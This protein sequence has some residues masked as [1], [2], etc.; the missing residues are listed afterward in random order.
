MRAE[1]SV[2]MPSYNVAPYIEECLLSVLRQSLVNIEIICVD[3]GSTDGTREIIEKYSQK[4]NRIIVID[5]PKKSYGLQM[6]L[7]I[8]R[9]TGEYIGI[10]ETDDY[11]A[12]D[13][14][15]ILYT[16]AV[17]N[18]L[19]CVRSGSFSFYIKD[20][21]RI[22][23]PFRVF[24]ENDPIYS[25]VICPLDY[26]EVTT[27]DG[28]VWRGIYRRSLFD[29]IEIFHETDGA[30]YQDIGFCMRV[31]SKIKRMKYTPRC[32]YYYRTDR[33]DSSSYK[34]DV[35][36]FQYQEYSWLLN[37]IKLLHTCPEMKRGLYLRMALTFLLEYDKALQA[38]GFDRDGCFI[39]P[40]FDFFSS[41]LETAIVERI[42][43][44]QDFP[45]EQWKKLRL[46]LED[47]DSYNN[48]R[49]KENEIEHDREIN[50]VESC[51]G[52]KVI[53]FG[54]GSYGKRV[55]EM[56]KDASEIVGFSD[57]NEELWGTRFNNVYV[58]KPDDACERYKDCLWIIA[59][60]YHGDEIKR[61]LLNKG[62][63]D[64]YRWR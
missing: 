42:I 23:T 27:H 50:L 22:Y 8:R 38:S 14:Y 59:N 24:E 40:Y 17:K 47:N 64:I 48:I 19:D 18:Q 37:D 55:F 33:P 9:A 34:P 25:K 20:N 54:C 32:L 53:I 49:K 5:S 63:S 21:E 4:D 58:F 1:V 44:E 61:Q 56:I 2:I 29:G 35:L 3:A 12:E 62:L 41:Q 26:P 11:I 7:G 39:A 15:E 31:F 36:R 57:N 43:S 16:I 10:V 30:A 52:K 45:P 51:K 46:I 13:M 60:K 6:N 28:N